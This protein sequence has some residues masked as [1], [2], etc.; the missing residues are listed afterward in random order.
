MANLSEKDD[1]P[2]L[3]D[4]HPLPKNTYKLVETLN[5]VG[6]ENTGKLENA[7]T[8]KDRINIEAKEK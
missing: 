1:L 8:A 7:D 4:D 6:E 5:D 2:T 3:G